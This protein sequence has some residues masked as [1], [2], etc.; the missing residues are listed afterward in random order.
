VVRRLQRVTEPVTYGD[1]ALRVP[2]GVDDVEADPGGLGRALDGDD[3]VLDGD[4]E[5][6]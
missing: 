4:G 2:D 5:P 3:A 6:V 1:D